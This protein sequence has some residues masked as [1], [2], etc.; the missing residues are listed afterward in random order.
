[1]QEGGEVLDLLQ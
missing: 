1:M